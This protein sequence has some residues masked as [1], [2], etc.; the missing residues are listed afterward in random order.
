[1]SALGCASEELGQKNKR[2]LQDLGDIEAVLHRNKI[3]QEKTA[4]N[5]RE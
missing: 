4:R 3:V 5:R 2:F 1:L